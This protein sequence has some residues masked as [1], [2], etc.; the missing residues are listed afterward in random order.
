MWKFA[1]HSGRGIRVEESGILV[2]LNGSANPGL[3]ADHHALEYKRVAEP[4]GAG[5][6]T[7]CRVDGG[8]DERG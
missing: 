7:V 1:Y 3:L 5:D 6:G 2:R 8:G 4:E